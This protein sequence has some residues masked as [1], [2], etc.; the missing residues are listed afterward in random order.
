MT[1]GFS[2]TWRQG[3]LPYARACRAAGV[4]VLIFDHA[5]FGESD[6]E[7]R[8]CVDWW[9]QV[10]EI[11]A[12]IDLLDRSGVD[13]SN[14][15]VFGF[16]LS[17]AVALMLA[18]LDTR[19]RAVVAVAPGP[20]SPPLA[21]RSTRFKELTREFHARSA[22]SSAASPLS[23]ADVGS[24]RPVIC[25]HGPWPSNTNATRQQ[26]KCWFGQRIPGAADAQTFFGRRGGP[27][28]AWVNAAAQ[29]LEAMPDWDAAIPFV[30]VPVLLICA[31]DDATKPFEDVDELLAALEGSELCKLHVVGSGG[32]FGLFDTAF[33]PEG[34][35]TALPG[36]VRM[37]AAAM[38]GFVRAALLANDG[39][40][41]KSQE[42]RLFEET[43]NASCFVSGQ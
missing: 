40:E 15:A 16:S 24:T 26:A 20:L 12:A 34:E 33:T 14:V 32:H 6:G 29:R 39:I 19:I 9:G 35:T 5:T 37:A 4:A 10:L 31:R 27:T 11:G 21:N 3:L 13:G 2:L 17:G 8:C 7:P 1:H 30:K 23:E 28:Y 42:Q 38:A 22:S 25:A 18:A 36:E 41:P 43:V